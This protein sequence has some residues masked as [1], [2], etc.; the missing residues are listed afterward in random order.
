MGMSWVYLILA[1]AFEVIGTTTLK[2]SNHIISF[3]MLAM[4]VSYG[5]SL[6]FL[7]L[8]TE[9]NR[10]WCSLCNLVRIRNHRY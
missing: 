2:G 5:F 8:S 9:K 3:K 10:H 7:S 1:I 6:L 4:L